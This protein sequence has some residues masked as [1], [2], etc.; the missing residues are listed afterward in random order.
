VKGI[1]KEYEQRGLLAGANFGKEFVN[2]PT[3]KL[4]VG[5]PA[6]KYEIINKIDF[7]P[8]WGIKTAQKIETVPSVSDNFYYGTNY[9]PKS[10]AVIPVLDYKV[11]N[12]LRALYPRQTNFGEYWPSTVFEVRCAMSGFDTWALYHILNKTVL[13]PYVYTYCDLQDENS[14]AGREFDVQ[15]ITAISN[16]D[17]VAYQYCS[18]KIKSGL[19][20]EEILDILNSLCSI[21]ST[22]GNEF[23]G[24]KFLVRLSEEPG[25]IFNNIKWIPEEYRVINAWDIADSAWI[26]PALYGPVRVD[27]YRD[28]AFYDAEGKLKPACEWLINESSLIKDFSNIS[29]SYEIQGRTIASYNVQVDRTV[30]VQ[31]GHQYALVTVPPVYID[32]G[33]MTEDRFLFDYMQ[34]LQLIPDADYSYNKLLQG[35]MDFS[36]VF[37]FPLVPAMDIPYVVG[38]PRQ[39]NKYSWGAW[40]NKVE[41]DGGTEVILE[42]SL[43]PETYGSYA[44]LQQVAFSAYAYIDNS[45]IGDTESGSI[46]VATIPEYN[47]AEKMGG[48]GPYLTGLDISISIDGITTSYK[49]NSWT[50]QFGRLNRYNADRISNINKNSIR[51]LQEQR[52]KFRKRELSS[53]FAD[54]RK[55]MEK[56]RINNMFNM[57]G[58]GAILNNLNP[59]EENNGGN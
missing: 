22:A 32:D 13:A 25:G 28:I 5:G 43:R 20:S 53:P 57:N 56:S 59:D 30:Y 6:S 15:A 9:S 11:S 26:E 18:G 1:V 8:V 33:Y 24:R 16:G 45:G 54:R 50:P 31:N 14:Y 38:V 3:Q 48:S 46:D 12:W 29:D 51:F 49:F 42:D 17:P 36:S 23:Y 47:L 19:I 39:S 37:A 55:N 27:S 58:I 10:N 7:I 4:V 40:W 34:V 21:I 2:S 41:G 52:Q 44:T 35:G